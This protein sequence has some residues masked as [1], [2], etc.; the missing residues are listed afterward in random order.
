MITKL[1]VTVIIVATLIIG[2]VLGAVGRGA[3]QKHH[4]QKLD[5]IERT[6]MFLSRVNEVVNPDS[7]QKPKVEKIA[8]RAAERVEI[9]FDHHQAEMA[10]IVDS[11]KSELSETLRPEQ[12]QRLDHEF[13]F[14]QQTDSAHEKLGV[15]MA[16]S[17]E[18]AERLQ[19][20]L[21]LDSAQTENLLLLVRESHDR[22]M[23]EAKPGN[24]NSEAAQKRRAAFL[25]ETNKKI[26]A[27]LNARQ[28]EQFRQL[29]RERERFVE[30]E[31]R[32]E[33]D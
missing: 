22:I 33:E 5:S 3:L 9:L 24:E 18:Y 31:L 10:I 8:K 17:Y 25:E 19:R 30:H 26:E 20:E 32:E 15:S 7:S 1:K 23:R 6:E 21:G 2:I 4:H 13:T 28:K 29:Q 16:F 12:Q 11:M 14:S 27:L